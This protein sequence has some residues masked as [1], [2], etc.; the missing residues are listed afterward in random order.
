MDL[1][2][3]LALG[4]LQIDQL[5][6]DINDL[7]FTPTRIRD[8]GLFEEQ[9]ITT[10]V[11][12][13][14]LDGSKL[15][16]VPAV[17]R[18]SPS[19]PKAI[20][21]KSAKPFI[22]PHLPQRSTVMA[23]QLQGARSFGAN[24]ASELESAAERVTA[25]NVVHRRDLDFTI[26]YHRLGAIKGT[27]LDAD[28][29]ELFDLYDEFGVTQP[30]EGFALATATTKVLTKTMSA[31]RKIEAALGGIRPAGFHAFVGS[32]WL[33]KFVEH[34]NVIRAYERYQEGAKLRSDNRSGFEFGGVVFEEYQGSY[35]GANLI[36]ANEGYMFPI[37][38]PGMFITRF[39]PADYV[40]T[41]NTV[42]LPYY[43]KTELMDF[44]K[45]VMLES[46]SNPLNLNTRPGA[47]VKLTTN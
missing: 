2:T 40:E 15:T 47:V 12:M 38:V 4:V 13:I 43:S 26:E 42:G 46:Q 45:G 20:G 30:T 10:T 35:G 21:P 25:L 28:G 5:T 18:G 36:T 29:S 24:G 32:E 6:A 14:G 31:K 44:G 34:E 3:L 11:A 8:M 16:L 17:P 37:G 1:A 19:Q 33:D 39:A 23:D 7:P 22:V 27:I 9:G 41:V